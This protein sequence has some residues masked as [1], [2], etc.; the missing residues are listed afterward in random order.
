MSTSS[1][2]FKNESNVYVENVSMMN[3]GASERAPHFTLAYAAHGSGMLL[4]NDLR[5]EVA[6]GDVLVKHN[7]N[8]TVQKLYHLHL[9]HGLLD[10]EP[11][12]AWYGTMRRDSLRGSRP[13]L[14]PTMPPP[15]CQAAFAA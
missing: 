5:H 10:N 7:C 1:A 12:A 2:L 6:E 3:E 11:L 4:I 8:T 13:G 15:H 14:Q 9:F